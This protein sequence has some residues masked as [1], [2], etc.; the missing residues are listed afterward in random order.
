MSD[1]QLRSFRDGVAPLALLLTANALA[2]RMT[3]GRIRGR[4]VAAII[5]LVVLHGVRAVE[6]L[7]LVAVNYAVARRL[8]HTRLLVP[9]TWLYAITSLFWLDRVSRRDHWPQWTV[10]LSGAMP[11][12]TVVFKMSVLRLISF[13]IDLR[14]S[15][16]SSPD[17]QET[18]HATDKT[19]CAKCPTTTQLDEECFSL[20]TL[21]AYVFYP[22]LYLSGPVLTFTDFVRQARGQTPRMGF[23]STARYG[24][25]LLASM[26]SLELI[27]HLFHVCALKTAAAW[28][29]AMSPLSYAAVAFLNL[30]IIWLK[31]LVIW[32]FARFFALTDGINPPENML[33]CMSNNY[34]ALGFWRSWH[35]SFN[36]WIVRYMYIPL[37][38]RHTSKWNLFPIFSFVALW[39]DVNWQLF[40]WGWLI[41]LFI[42]PEV[43]GGFVA[44]RLQLSN[45]L[46]YRHY[47]AIGASFNIFL[48]MLANLVGFSVGL[49]GARL[50]LDKIVSGGGVCFVASIF[51]V[52]FAAAQIMFEVREEER[53]VLGR[54]KNY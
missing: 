50:M 14:Q 44:R 3:G 25:R 26:L 45:S 8:R 4:L 21:L 23:A 46:H 32:R 22:P 30:K 19:R 52:F 5:L 20:A 34:S 6:P 15:C 47:C 18:R 53:R 54:Y 37:G 28:T 39:H 1:H 35:R 40:A 9:F 33:R 2:N 42:L 16:V 12:W 51:V 24:L 10:A 48:M 29:V 43:A 31:L 36:Q 38:G 49:D 41:P 27:L 7:V 11:R 13:N 17:C